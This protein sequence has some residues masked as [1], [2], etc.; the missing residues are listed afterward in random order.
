MLTGR[1]ETLVGLLVA[2]QIQLAAA[3][4]IQ[5]NRIVDIGTDARFLH[6]GHSR[7]GHHERTLIVATDEQEF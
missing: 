3:D 1:Q 4:I 6:L 2:P 7:H 5:E